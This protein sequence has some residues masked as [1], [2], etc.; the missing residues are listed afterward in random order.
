MRDNICWETSCSS[1]HVRPVVAG[2][3]RGQG[4]RNP[5]RRLGERYRITSSR[6]V[7]NGEYVRCATNT[8]P[9][10]RVPMN[11]SIGS[12]PN[13]DRAVGRSM[14]IPSPRMGSQE[15][16]RRIGARGRGRP[17]GVNLRDIQERRELQSITSQVLR[18][19]HRYAHG[20]TPAK[21]LPTIL[22][23]ASSDSPPT[24]VTSGNAMFVDSTIVDVETGQ[25]REERVKLDVTPDAGTKMRVVVS[26]KGL[27][28]EPVLNVVKTATRSATVDA[29]TLPK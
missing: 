12:E 1:T 10:N 13:I 3:L 14:T 18:P 5:C 24:L 19:F 26:P 27:V 9:A 23:A 16:A 7:R 25:L 15:Q 22:G 11:R 20:P 21:P 29:M 6:T 8:G 28:K 17:Q 4:S 2:R